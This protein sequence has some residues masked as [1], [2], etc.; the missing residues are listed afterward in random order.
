MPRNPLAE[1]AVDTM[2]AIEAL[3]LKRHRLVS[4]PD[5][6]IVQQPG[7]P[8]MLLTWRAARDFNNQIEEAEHG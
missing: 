3:R 6:V 5:G 2:V 1:A 8:D 4:S 7:K